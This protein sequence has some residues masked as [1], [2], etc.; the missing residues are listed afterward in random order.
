MVKEGNTVKVHYTGKFEDDKVF[1]TS[2]ERE[3]I[4]FKVGEGMMIPG[5]ENG[6]VGLTVGES[7]TLKITPEEGYGQRNDSLINEI[8]LDKLPEGVVKGAL[9]QA[10][11]EQGPMN[12]VVSEVKEKT[13]MIDANHPLAGKNLVFDIELVEI[14]E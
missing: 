1:D 3:P 7:K 8:T 5:F 4:S 10:Q 9:L 13:A 14:S 6:V 2:K 12:V 11:T